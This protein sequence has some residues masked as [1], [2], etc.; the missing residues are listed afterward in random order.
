MVEDDDEEESSHDVVGEQVVVVHNNQDDRRSPRNSSANESRLEALRRQLRLEDHR[1]GLQPSS[2]ASS[3]QPPKQQPKPQQRIPQ[4][5]LP[6]IP[7]MES[8]RKES[9]G[10]DLT[11][12]QI[13]Q[14]W[15]Q[16]LETLPDPIANPEIL[17]DTFQR[18]HTYLRI[19]LSEK[20]NL[21]CLYCMPEDGVPLQPPDQLLSNDE[22][23]QLVDWFV[24]IGGITKL[25]FTGGEPLLRKDL[26]KLI[27]TISRRHPQLEEIGLTTNGVTL[28]KHLPDL[29]NA[30]V[31]NINISLDSLQP[32]LFSKLTRRPESYFD[33]VW[34]SIEQATSTYQHQLKTKINCVVMPDN[35]NELSEFAMLTHSHP[36]LDI[37]FI[38][39]MPFNDNSWDTNQFI[40][41]Q[42]MQDILNSSS[43]P[44][45]LH[46]LSDGPNDTTKWW[47]YRSSSSENNNNKTGRIGFITSMTSHFCST[48]NRLRI[49]AD[50][51]LKVC[52]FG[53]TEISLRDILR[54][55]PSGERL[56]PKVV[57]A[58]VQ[59]KHYKLG[60]HQDMNDISN[61]S[62][63][64]RPM[65]LIGG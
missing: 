20:C 43:S 32:A 35:Q 30:G 51:Q 54:S 31:T 57:H 62:S 65:T 12:E 53:S 36:N 56:L 52:L 22:I 44:Y 39:Y 11:K 27:D 41:Y 63:E 16:Q 5:K 47:S 8:I 26:A 7:S 19:S 18:Q 23:L 14:R 42:N 6:P 64:N 10:Q 3:K 59:R 34:D 60:G 17:Q 21:R 2:T 55:S 33:R 37:R 40:S 24:T 15:I 58:A 1:R 4:S 13:Q 49:T 48:C 46:R 25:R 45:Q 28:S 9:D 50:G 38:E 61:H 29:V